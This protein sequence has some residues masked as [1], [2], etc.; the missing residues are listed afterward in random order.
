MDKKQG[1]SANA[2]LTSSNAPVGIPDPD[3]N[4][5]VESPTLVVPGSTSDTLSAPS[6]DGADDTSSPAAGG[7]SSAPASGTLTILAATGKPLNQVKLQSFASALK[8]GGGGGG[9]PASQYASA[10]KKPLMTVAVGPSDGPDYLVKCSA[11]LKSIVSVNDGA[12]EAVG[13]FMDRVG[14]DVLDAGQ[15]RSAETLAKYSLG[16]ITSNTANAADTIP[17]ALLSAHLTF[18]YFKGGKYIKVNHQ[19]PSIP[20]TV[21]PTLSTDTIEVKAVVAYIY[22][23]IIASIA[24]SPRIVSFF[25]NINTNQMIY[26][27][28]AMPLWRNPD[29]Y[30]FLLDTMVQYQTGQRSIRTLSYTTDPSDPKGSRPLPGMIIS[31][32][33]NNVRC[34]RGLVLLASKIVSCGQADERVSVEGL[35]RHIYMAET[36]RD[37]YVRLHTECL[38]YANERL[39]VIPEARFNS[40]ACS[41]FFDAVLFTDATDAAMG[42]IYTSRNKLA[43]RAFKSPEAVE[44]RRL[45]VERGFAVPSSAPVITYSSRQGE[46]L[47]SSNALENSLYSSEFMLNLARIAGENG[48]EDTEA[49][50]D[51]YTLGVAYG[52]LWASGAEGREARRGQ[53]RPSL[54]VEILK[55]LTRSTN[56]VFATISVEVD[57]TSHRDTII[58]MLSGM[59]E[60]GV[61]WGD[62]TYDPDGIPSKA[63]VVPQIKDVRK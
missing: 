26:S 12:P 25:Q 16:V 20:K 17:L 50:T 31:I 46:P 54:R 6:L 42:A 33:Q 27:L 11:L 34:P 59:A 52:G 41:Q 7:G 28:F 5:V 53:A 55:Y 49:L 62:I 60:L 39:H 32:N 14:A 18:N 44:A 10:S 1:T 13:A 47:W 21:P 57:S 9:S 36:Y 45:T 23:E 61:S 22:A 40:D 43:A 48:I 15:C 19:I 37:E 56:S 58:A 8:S 24:F 38:R 4:F 63:A 51:I 30:R 29:T 3:T 2:S 35:I